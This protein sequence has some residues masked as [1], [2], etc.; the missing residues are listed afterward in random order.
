VKTLRLRRHPI[1][2]FLIV[3][4]LA[5]LL[6][7]GGVATLGAEAAKENL[8]DRQARTSPEWLTRGVM[9]Q[10]WLRAFTP[11]G[12]LAAATKRLASVAELGATIVY[13]PP[14]SLAD[15]DMREEFW[16][17]RQIASGCNNP[18]NPYRIDDYNRIDPEYGTDADLCEFVAEAHRRGLRVLV[19]LVYLH[20]GPA[21]VLAK[22]PG[23]LKGDASGQIT[24]GPWRFPLL[25]FE[26]RALREYLF[27]NMERWIKD[28]DLDGFRCDVADQ[29]PLDFWEEARRRLQPI[30]PDLVI[31][32]EGGKRENLL[33]AF[34]INYGYPWYHAGQNVLTKSHSASAL[35]ANWQATH[36]TYPRGSKVIR[37]T[38]N[39]DIVNDL[40]RADV[41]FGRQGAAAMS[42]INFTI[43]G[44]PFL[45]NGQ[46]FGDTGFQSIYAQWP[47]YWEAACLPESKKR[48]A[49]YQKL[50][51]LRRDERA[52]TD[53]EVV[54]LDSNQPDAVVAFLRCLGN[55]RI[56][57]VANLSNRKM[58]A[59]ITL[60]ADAATAYAPLLSTG[61]KITTDGGFLAADLNGFAYFVGKKK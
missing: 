5:V 61:A 49:F 1:Q 38:E 58:T 6:L 23:F 50:C 16:S 52:L 13:L 3:P 4:L 26:N 46:E 18:R 8:S 9:Y 21:S 41:V 20:C 7:S 37:F 25:N 51:Q 17:P 28:F 48:F 29:V 35:R 24:K 15:A 30:R 10:V 57:T 14:I 33:E 22:H 36:D 32:A 43:D 44:V 12:T 55:E 27:A 42:V 45:Y 19:D 11:E 60:P 34:D 54:W 47:I 40:Q 56:V 2:A 31:L 39:H 53:G 59:K